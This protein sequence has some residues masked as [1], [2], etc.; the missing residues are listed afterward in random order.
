MKGSSAVLLIMFLLVAAGGWFAAGVAGPKVG[1][2]LIGVAIGVIVSMPLTLLVA[3][4][5]WADHVRRMRRLERRR[6]R[7][8]PSPMT[9]Y[10]PPV[11]VVPSGRYEPVEDP[12]PTY[13]PQGRTPDSP[14]I[15]FLGEE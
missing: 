13:R 4:M 1:T 8:R 15:H 10:P 2:L 5:L 12:P 3:R 6:H 11:I 9:E 7:Y 14:P